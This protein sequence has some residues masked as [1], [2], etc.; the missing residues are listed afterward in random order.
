MQVIFNKQFLTDTQVNKPELS[1]VFFP[2]PSSYGPLAIPSSHP[3]QL[4]LLFGYLFLFRWGSP[5]SLL[6]VEILSIVYS[7]SQRSLFS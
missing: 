7:P 1:E 4:F 5:L 2:R 6:P 3:T